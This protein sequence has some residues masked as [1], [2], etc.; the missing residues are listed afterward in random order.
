MKTTKIVSSVQ[1]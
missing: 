1:L